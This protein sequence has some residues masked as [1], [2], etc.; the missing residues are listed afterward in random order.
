MVLNHLRIFNADP[1]TIVSN[2]YYEIISSMSKVYLVAHHALC[3]YHLSY[4]MV[5]DTH[6]RPAL[7]LFWASIRAIKSV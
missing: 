2:R 1:S 4:N 6:D 7:G 5:T 3:Y